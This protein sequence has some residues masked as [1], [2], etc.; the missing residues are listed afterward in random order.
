[1]FARQLEGGVPGGP[2]P[3]DPEF[4][5]STAY[6]PGLQL[7]V[8]CIETALG[9]VPSDDAEQEAEPSLEGPGH[10]DV[11]STRH[12]SVQPP[13]P[14]HTVSVRAAKQRLDE[15][16]VW[17]RLRS[18]VHAGSGTVEASAASSWCA[19]SVVAPAS[20]WA[21]QQVAPPGFTG[22]GLQSCAPVGAWTQ[23]GPGPGRRQSPPAAAHAEPTGEDEVHAA[24]SAASRSGVRN[25]TTAERRTMA[26]S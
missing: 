3:V 22:G 8:H 10:C 26:S 16:S 19:A 23:L 6:S 7:S 20:T 12:T 17:N 15:P 13:T 5:H 11:S 21:R 2:C 4:S 1:V 18:H 25:R 24:A 9:V 14:T